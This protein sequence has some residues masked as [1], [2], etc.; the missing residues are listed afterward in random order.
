MSAGI[1]DIV[2]P[3]RQLVILDGA[4]HRDGGHVAGNDRFG[5]DYRLSG[6][7]VFIR[8]DPLL[9][10]LAG[11]E[12]ILGQGAD[13]FAR[14]PEVLGKPVDDIKILAGVL[15][16]NVVKTQNTHVHISQD[17]SQKPSS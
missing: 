4:E 2:A 16:G 15:V 11:N 17:I 8:Q 7:A 13:G 6:V 1:R 12:G 3:D 10:D 14:S 5:G 9:E